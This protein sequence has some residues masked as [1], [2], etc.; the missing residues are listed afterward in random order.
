MNITGIVLAGGKSSRYGKQKIFESYQGIPFY[1]HSVQAFIQGGVSSVYIVTNKEL[2]VSFSTNDSPVIPLIIEQSKHEGPLNALAAAM[3]TLKKTD[4][5]F[6]LP[7]DVP[8]IQPDFVHKMISTVTEEF[9]AFI[10]VT[11]KKQQ[12]LHGVYHCS[13]LPIIEQLLYQN[14]KSMKQL[15]EKLS[16]YF[17]SFSSECLDFTNINHKEDWPS[18]LDI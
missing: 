14:E 8:F 15:I 1:S 12:P 17:L 10:P 7:A 6:I 16:V 5:F 3:Q 4:W 13:S 11:R 18:S 9:D 2:S